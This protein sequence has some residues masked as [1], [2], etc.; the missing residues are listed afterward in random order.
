[1][2]LCE[3]RDHILIDHR[4]LRDRL[5]EIEELV[6]SVASGRSERS[7][8]LC[9]R[10]VELLEALE[11]R[12]AWEERHLLPAIRDF[13]GD[14]RAARAQDDQRTQREL[15]RFQLEALTDRQRPPLLIAFGLRDFATLLRDEMEQEEQLFFHPDLLRD[16]DVFVDIETT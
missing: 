16:D 7:R 5:N 6:E 4:I 11:S 13:Y 1:M 14:E 10:G 3:V 15:L 8:F 12:M 2:G 9:T